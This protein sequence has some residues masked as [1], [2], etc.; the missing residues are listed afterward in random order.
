[1]P[2]RLPSPLPLIDLGLLMSGEAVRRP[3]RVSAGVAR[4]WPKG[5]GDERE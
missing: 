5:R 2:N 1:M 4:N 3:W